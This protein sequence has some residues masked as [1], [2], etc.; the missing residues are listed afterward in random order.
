MSLP[1]ESGKQGGTQSLGS[2]QRTSGLKSFY[3]PNWWR[4]GLLFI[5]PFSS[6][7]PLVIIACQHRGDQRGTRHLHFAVKIEKGHNWIFQEEDVIR[8]VDETPFSPKG[9]ELGQDWAALIFPH[10]G[11]FCRH[12]NVIFTD[13]T[14]P[15]PSAMSDSDP[16][17]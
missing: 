14:L 11:A 8:G 4:E 13:I 1:E 5:S 17:P 15:E 6:S 3:F 12:S 9:P 16:K 7:R 2:F 10:P